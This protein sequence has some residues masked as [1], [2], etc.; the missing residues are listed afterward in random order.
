M[1]F[2]KVA[3][4]AVVLGAVVAANVAVAQVRAVP[5][6]L[7]MMS[8]AT[9]VVGPGYLGIDMRDVND[10]E[11]A[12]LHLRDGRG[13]VI[14]RVDHD[15]PAGKAGLRERD[16]VLNVN[17]VAIEGEEQLRKNL[18]EM[19][20]GRTVQ[21]MIA[22]DGAMLTISAMLANREELEKQAW[23]QHWTVPAPIRDSNT[24]DAVVNSPAPASRGFAHNF[25][26]GSLMAKPLYTGVTMDAMGAQLADF[27]GVKDG[28]GLL[29]HGVDAN[30]PAATAGLHAGDVITRVNG[31]GVRSSSDWT[32]ALRDSKGHPVSLTVVRDRH[33][34]TLT[35]VPEG[36]HRS[37]VNPHS[38]PLAMFLR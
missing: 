23:G 1:V 27:F 18:R 2:S 9:H 4:V 21:M 38:W 3:G 15:G 19:Q 37:D 24:D 10:D 25:V 31:G 8:A 14:I 16:V 36:K 28:K 33:E 17:G 32:K 5:A 35:M 26:S 30:S 12:T 7:G 13:A 34:Q 22:R 6:S 20:P 29:V 11:I